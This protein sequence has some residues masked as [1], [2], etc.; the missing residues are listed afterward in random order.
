MKLKAFS[1]LELMIAILLSGFVISAI[2]SGYVFTYKQF[3]KFTSIKTEIRNYF[4]LTEVLNREFENAKKVTKKSSTEIQ[5]ESIDKTIYYS[6]N[7]NT[8]IRTVAEQTDTFFFGVTAIKMNT[9]NELTQDPI[10][11]YL[12]LTIGNEE[13]E[14][15]L[16]FYKY[17]GAVTLIEE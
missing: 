17:Y 14:K 8:I 15:S 9:I 5:I 10:V 13:K 11:D 1:L 2:Y 16:S 12:V 3:Y 4:E 6:F 7:D